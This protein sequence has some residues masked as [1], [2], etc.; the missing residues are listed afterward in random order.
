MMEETNDLAT[1]VQELAWAL[2]DEQATDGQ[3]RRL[4]ELLLGGH[5]AR[6]VYVTCMQ[7]HS[8]LHYLLGG[9]QPR[10]PP[11]LEA[12]IKAEKKARPTPPLVD[13]PPIIANVPYVDG[14]AS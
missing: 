4:E 3:I 14:C 1:E 12:A 11:A 9:R 8:D 10:L 6:Q 5:E 2:V 7:M 13:L